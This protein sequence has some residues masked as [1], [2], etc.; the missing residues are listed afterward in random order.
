MNEPAS[1]QQPPPSC[2]D[3]KWWH[4]TPLD[5]RNLG[6]PPVGHCNGA[7]PVPVLIPIGPGQFTFRSV[8][9]TFGPDSVICRLFERRQTIVA[10]GGGQ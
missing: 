10:E 7:P 3:C 6:A 8:Y 5:P 9:P 4:R 2:G 1:N